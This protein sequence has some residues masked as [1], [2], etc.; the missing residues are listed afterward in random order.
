MK[1]GGILVNVARGEIINENDLLDALES[2]HLR[3]AALD[4]YNGEFE[5]LPD[6]RLWQRP[7]VLITPHNS[8]ATDIS[9]HRAFEIFREYLDDYLQDRPLDNVIDWERG[10]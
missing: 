2:G 5:K 6:T 10:Y 3:G 8:G 1:K 4:V 7:D 9:V